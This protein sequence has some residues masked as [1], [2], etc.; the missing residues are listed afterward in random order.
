MQP[1][2]S[3]TRPS[4]DDLLHNPFVLQAAWNKAQ[5]WYRSSEWAPE[6]EFETWQA[7]PW[8]HLVA[9]ADDLA[10]GQFTPSP[11]KLIPYPK[12]GA[13]IRNYYMPELRDQVAH[14]IFAVLL[15]PFLE[16]RFAN[17]AFGNRWYRGLKQTETAD[18]TRP[19]WR[20]TPFSLT[21]PQL[22]VPYRRDYSLFRRLAQWTVSQFLGVD[23]VAAVG[24]MHDHVRPEQYDEAM[25]PYLRGTW[26]V[27]ASE[28]RALC[29][30]RLDLRKAYPSVN[31]GDLKANLLELLGDACPA[32]VEKL[33]APW[34]LHRSF[35]DDF[36]KKVIPYPFSS[37][38]DDMAHPWRVLAGAGG[39]SLRLALAERWMSLFENTRAVDNSEFNLVR[40]LSYQ[41]ESN[42][43]RL[44][45]IPTGL[46]VGGLMMQ[47]ALSRLDQDVL[48]HLENS[49]VAQRLPGAYLRFVDD[50]IILATDRE[51]LT[52]LLRAIQQGLSR[53][54]PTEQGLRLEVNWNKAKPDSLKKQG[55]NLATE[56]LDIKDSDLITPERR[57]EFVTDLVERLS[58]LQCESILMQRTARGYER[59]SRL[60]ELS[61]WN[62]QDTE[63]R[64]D[65]RITFALNALTRA[66]LPKGDD[67]SRK[68]Q[69]VFVEEIRSAAKKALEEAPWKSS[70]WRA[71]VRAALRTKLDDHANT[72]GLA[73][74]R[75]ILELV[76]SWETAWPRFDGDPVP[77]DKGYE[78]WKRL[79][80]DGFRRARVSFLRTCFWREITKTIRE[81]SIARHL[82]QENRIS[83][84]AWH[85]RVLG[86]S[87]ADLLRAARMLGDLDE[88]ARI[89]YPQDQELPW[90]ETDALRMARDVVKRNLE[91]D[92]VH[93]AFQNLPES[94]GFA[95]DE[96]IKVEQHC[97]DMLRYETRGG[98]DLAVFLERALTVLAEQ[99]SS[100]EDAPHRYFG[101]LHLYQRLRTLM[102]SKQLE[103]PWLLRLM[104]T[105]GVQPVEGTDEH[106]GLHQLLWSTPSK[107]PPSGWTL[108]P[109]HVPSL[110]LPREWAIRFYADILALGHRTGIPQPCVTPNVLSLFAATRRHDLGIEAAE[111]KQPGFDE[112][113]KTAM[114]SDTWLIPP[115]PVHLIPRWRAWGEEHTTSW[116]ASF[117]LFLALEGS[118]DLHDRIFRRFPTHA[119]W[120][121]VLWL[122]CKHLLPKCVWNEIDYALGNLAEQRGSAEVIELAE[123][124]H[125]LEA[126]TREGP[127]HIALD[128]LF[129]VLLLEPPSSI[130]PSDPLLELMNISQ[131]IEVRIPRRLDPQE[132]L[133]VRLAQLKSVPKFGE[134]RN[135]PWPDSG[136]SFHEDTLTEIDRTVDM[137][138]SVEAD[139]DRP[140]L[141][142]FPEATIPPDQAAQIARDLAS[143]DIGMIGGLFWRELEPPV[144]GGTAASERLRYFANEAILSI[145][146]PHNPLRYPFILTVR[147]PRPANIEH[148][149]QKHFLQGKWRIVPG[150]EWLMFEHEKW[151][152]F[153]I[154]IC[155]D[156]LDPAP[157]AAMRAQILHLFLVAWN[158]DIELYKAMSRTRAY[159]L[160][161]NLVVVNHG[162]YGGSLAWTPRSGNSKLLFCVEGNDH[163]VTADVT[164]DVVALAERHALSIDQQQKE[165][166]EQAGTVL[167]GTKYA[168][169]RFKA[170][171]L[172]PWPQASAAIQAIANRQKSPPGTS[173]LSLSNL[174]EE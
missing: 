155:S 124:H 133:R 157:W 82:L 123:T 17:I 9:L 141:V 162:E 35:E 166:E 95:T 122:R 139:G 16:A 70:I 117:A 73:W 29:Y 51:Q 83:K 135:G 164:L 146:N 6:P 47:V 65:T 15:A 67:R 161:V 128:P 48:S 174:P 172:T 78:T 156:I 121:E 85:R 2:P 4:L 149:Y 148:G 154:A 27:K 113:E 3:Q 138:I 58:E 72:D 74:L 45:G 88:W 84:H 171:P 129:P 32:G 43:D 112:S 46:A 36:L 87:D 102:L 49:A 93:R 96:W 173:G 94:P 31:L 103:R 71:I 86:T 131:A 107:L 37:E 80:D 56:A 120:S 106:I 34:G 11:L 13:Q 105:M 22:Y 169:G 147:K 5:T 104:S 109:T 99:A 8:P 44:S 25:L 160:Y 119:P 140:N 127:L 159:E 137:L 145:P 10:S 61:R 168:R 20:T 76:A 126:G 130:E 108:S 40:A 68:L 66:W 1:L 92:A 118:E 114:W 41:I 50:I 62:I 55:E 153:A 115:H 23:E 151:G 132:S 100:P 79:D 64:A 28:N 165:N 57:G 136:G 42:T 97:G 53:Y 7:A 39:E 152:P 24:E 125:L 77:E 144:H 38:V 167:D 150:K 75:G 98:D 90:W 52:E 59:L 111:T 12:Q 30:A 33:A 170:L 63:I 19:H 158:T 91:V 81:L 142:V 110:G 134:L 101:A 60:L 116:H 69:R 21:D 143:R 54:N 89:L 163:F 26:R 14:L 18:G